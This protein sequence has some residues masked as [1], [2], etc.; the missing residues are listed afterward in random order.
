MTDPTRPRRPRGSR[1]APATSTL[2]A[3]VCDA[4]CAVEELRDEITEWQENLE[5]NGME[6][7][8]KYEDVSETALLL[9]QAVGELDTLN[10]LVGD[11]P[12]EIQN[13]KLDYTYDS[14]RKAWARWGR[15]S[16]GQV[17]A[18]VALEAGRE[19][20]AAAQERADEAETDLPDQMEEL[21]G[22]LDAWEEGITTTEDVCFPGMY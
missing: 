12:D 3:L 4:Y 2:E 11:L 15:L 21:E 5:C 13:Q 10:D 22:A 14:R 9:D 19:A 18:Q 17:M 7:L 20:L 8:P 6:H 1:N 16:N